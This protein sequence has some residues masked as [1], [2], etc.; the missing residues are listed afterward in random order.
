M[1]LFIKYGIKF[2]VKKKNSNIEYRGRGVNKNSYIFK[3]SNQIRNTE[4]MSEVTLDNK[5]L[6]LAEI[7]SKFAEDIANVEV[8]LSSYKS[9]TVY[10]QDQDVLEKLKNQNIKEYGFDNEN[11]YQWSLEEY[12]AVL[13]HTLIKYKLNENEIIFAVTSKDFSKIFAVFNNPTGY[14]GVNCF[15]SNN[16]MVNLR[17]GVLYL[18]DKFLH[19]MFEYNNNR[20][21]FDL[22]RTVDFNLGDKYQKN[23]F[24]R[25]FKKLNITNEKELAVVLKNEVFNNQR[26]ILV[27]NNNTLLKYSSTPTDTDNSWPIQIFNSYDSEKVPYIEKSELYCNIFDACIL[28]N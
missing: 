21:I 1:S 19:K 24:D 17:S 4:N 9:Q 10:W 3:N 11:E 27:K 15:I 28:N 18:D 22:N 26:G 25:L 12:K 14:M 23:F 20:V 2:C 8:Y 16:K 5:N 7:F 13:K 6:T